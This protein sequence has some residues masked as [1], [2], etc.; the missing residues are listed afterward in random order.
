MVQYVAVLTALIRGIVG[1]KSS[2]RP[3]ISTKLPDLDKPDRRVQHLSRWLHKEEIKE[4][5]YFLPYA[6]LLY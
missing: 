6:E 4:E 2:Q 1:S 3:S 5:I